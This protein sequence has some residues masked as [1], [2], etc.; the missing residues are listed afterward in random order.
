MFN[1]F[2]I[3]SNL[4]SFRLSACLIS[5]AELADANDVFR[6]IRSSN[7]VCAKAYVAETKFPQKLEPHVAGDAVNTGSP[8]GGSLAHGVPLSH[9]GRSASR[10]S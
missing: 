6:V 5:V 8:E 2:F 4:Q 9:S 7:R 1:R 3:V 10:S